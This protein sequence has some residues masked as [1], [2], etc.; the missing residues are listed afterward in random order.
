[1]NHRLMSCVAALL[2]S[3]GAVAQPSLP[4][5][6]ANAVGQRFS[7]QQIKGR[8]AM[9]FYWS[10]TCAVC[11][12]SLP[13]LRANA[14]GWRG[15]PFAIVYVNVDRTAEDWLAY[16]HI[17]AR[18]QL[19][20]D[21]PLSL[22]QDASVAAPPRLPLTVLIDAQGKVVARFEGRMAPEAWDLVADLLP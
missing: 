22:H 11:R 2:F 10:T 13:E 1:M 8:V 14:A 9:V 12:D 5:Q 20:G 17:A 19:G 21:K 16:E 6:A 7:P 18:V 3:L 15:K 4:L